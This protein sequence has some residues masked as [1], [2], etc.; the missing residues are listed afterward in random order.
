MPTLLLLDRLAERVNEALFEHNDTAPAVQVVLG[1]HAMVASTGTASSVHSVLDSTVRDQAMN[2]SIEK[3]T[4]VSCE[5][6]LIWIS[7]PTVASRGAASTVM[8]LDTKT[9][10]PLTEVY[11]D[12]SAAIAEPLVH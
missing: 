2:V 4:S 9:I 11:V 10:L 7:C 5:L 6:P 3:L 12:S 1:L 8:L